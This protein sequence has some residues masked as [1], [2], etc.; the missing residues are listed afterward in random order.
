MTIVRAS[1]ADPQWLLSHCSGRRAVDIR[2]GISRI[3]SA[4]ILL[5]GTALP[6]I[7]DFAGAAGTSV[8]T[9]ADAWGSLRD[10]GLIETRRRGGT[11]VAGW[12]KP[13]QVSTAS[14]GFAGWSSI[15]LVQSNADVT[16]QPSLGAALLSSL[17]ARD[18]NA[19][20]RDYMTER[21]RTVVEADW[22]FESQAWATAGGG[23]EALL[24]ATAAAAP[25]G[26]VIAI[27]EPAAPGFLD[28][29][30]DLGITPIGVSVDESGPRPESL[31]AA[32]EKRP[33]AF[34]YQPGGPFAIAHQVTEKRVAELADVLLAH[35]EPVWVI[36]DDSIGPLAVEA[37]PSMGRQLPDRVLRIRSYCKAYG[38]DVRTS[39][40]GGSK[41][42]VQ[43]SVKE[44][45]RGVGSNSRIL[46]NTLAYLIGSDDARAS[47]E[48]ARKHYG[49]RR[50]LLVTALEN[51]GLVAHTGP[52]S[53][54]VWIDVDNETD[55]LVA[56]AT[57]GISVGSGRKSFVDHPDRGLLRISVTQLPDDRVLIEQLAQII[58]N[59]ASG[60][61]REYF[62]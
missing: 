57:Q 41:E 9:I 43:R 14:A 29:L 37:S 17:D 39:V 28:T 45:S 53:L 50:E 33:V 26:S 6:T 7:R 42:L 62:D 16:L 51:A 47:V 23:T 60:S 19:S 31:R 27:D 40:L 25:R 13:A 21:L 30:R 56:L 46:Q 8:G 59:A 20:G 2:D 3:I 49:A 24:L 22:P 15:D 32:L 18:L 34:V 48:N 5:P 52:H 58:A 11:V 61:L 1:S 4:G 12:T 38:I 10:A 44:R 35:D 36:E 54:V 55:A